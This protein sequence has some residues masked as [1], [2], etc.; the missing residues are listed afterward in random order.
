MKG[1]VLTPEKGMKIVELISLYYT[2]GDGSLFEVV[3]II[4]GKS[5]EDALKGVRNLLS[6]SK[7]FAKDNYEN[8]DLDRL[9]LQ[10]YNQL[11]V[12]I[13]SLSGIISILE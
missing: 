10:H 2:K 12:Q 1:K 8:K 4:E 5:F 11:L 6:H 9:A 7:Q 13:E 3:E